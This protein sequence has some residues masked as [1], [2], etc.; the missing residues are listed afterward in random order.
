MSS[1]RLLKTFLAVAQHGTFA[2]AGGHV[3]LTAAAVGLQIRALEA[4]MHCQLFDRSARA[5]ILNPAGR[6]IVPEV[7][8][9]VRRYD[10]MCAES[11]GDA[12][13]GPVVVGALVSALMGAFADALWSMRQRYP[14]LDVHLFTGLSSDFA[15]RV[16]RGELDAAIVTQSP[17]PLLSN[18]LWTPLYSEPMILIVPRRPHF[19]LPDQPE[20]ILRQAPFMRFDRSTWT[21]YLV[22]DA[23]DQCNMSV[24]ESMELNS[25]ET[26]IELVRQ[27]F[28]VSIV[29]KLAN[30]AWSSDD[31]LHVIALPGIDVSRRVGLLERAT[32]SRTTFTQTIKSYFLESAVAATA[33]G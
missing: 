29:P 25:V 32:H 1:I 4:D 16:E 19:V 18:L 13:S 15:K 17:R 12:M 7:E 23:L 3:G 8:E 2:A 31:T 10:L 33:L 20:D 9:I 22:Q 5:A 6:A 26:I 27:G 21:G 28:G 11:S 30:V 24:R 14:R